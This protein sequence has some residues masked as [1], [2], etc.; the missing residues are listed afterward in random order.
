[1]NTDQSAG[2]DHSPNSDVAF[3]RLV[4]NN[5]NIEYVARVGGGTGFYGATYGDVAYSV[6]FQPDPNAPTD[7]PRIILGG[8][9]V[10]S[11]NATPY[12]SGARFAYDGPVDPNDYEFFRSNFASPNGERGDQAWELRVQTTDN[13]IVAG[14]F[15]ER[16]DTPTFAAI[17]LC[18][19]P[20]EDPCQGAGAAPSSGGGNGDG[21]K[22]P[23]WWA[24]SDS[25][26]ASSSAHRVLNHS[27]STWQMEP[28]DG[29]SAPLAQGERFS[30]KRRQMLV[31]TGD[32][33]R[34]LGGPVEWSIW[35]VLE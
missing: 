35:D 4:G 12:M 13:H 14:G 19:D 16:S 26:G 5:G 28:E 24:L 29:L 18:K 21:G 11:N 9:S 31:H 3:A 10:D 20:G 27:S 7:P 34:A 33:Q 25:S 32:S 22:S 17:R 2:T 6:V 8:Y 23:H 1:V 15:R 30:I